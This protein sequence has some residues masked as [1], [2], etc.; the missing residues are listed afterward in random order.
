[1]HREGK[2]KVETS[3]K[4]K[5]IIMM[6]TTTQILSVGTQAS[7]KKIPTGIVSTGTSAGMTKVAVFVNVGVG[8]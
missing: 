6:K 5:G 3:T 7:L 1:M 8:V 4:N 2:A